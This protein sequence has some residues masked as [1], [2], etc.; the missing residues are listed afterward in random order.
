MYLPKL[1]NIYD[2]K[3]V[4]TSSLSV[5]G[6]GFLVAAWMISVGFSVIVAAALIGAI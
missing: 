4:L 5:F 1:H 3:K 2:V 6:G